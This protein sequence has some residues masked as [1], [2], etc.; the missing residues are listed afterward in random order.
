MHQ[1]LFFFKKLKSHP[2][3]A[4]FSDDQVN[5]CRLFVKD[6]ASKKCFLI[7]TGA[8]V[9]V[10][11]PSFHIPINSSNLGIK[12]FAANG[13]QI[14]TFGTK[15][16]HLDLGLRRN[17]S[18]NFIIADVSKPIIGSD[19]L[20]YYHLLP[21]LKRKAL[22]DG[23][24][25]LH[26]SGKLLESSSL[27]IKVLVH[28]DSVYNKLLLNYPDVYQATAI[29]GIKSKHNI[30]H[31]IETTG[32]PVFAKAR[33]LDPN[34]LQIAKKDF[35]FLLQ[36]GIIRPSKSNW[37]NPLHMV[38]KKNGEWRCVGDYRF[39]NKITVPDRYPIPF[40]TD[41]NVNIAGCSVF[42]KLDL[43]RTFYQIPVYPDDISKTAVIT[44]FGLYEF[45]KMPFGLRNA[46]QSFQRLMDEVLRGLP[47]VFVYIDDV[48]LFSKSTTEHLEHLKIIFDRFQEYGIVVNQGKCSFGKYE[49]DFL[50]FHISSDGILPTQ[51]KI[52]AI[53]NFPKPESIKDL[54]RFLAMINFYR[55]FLPHA[56][57]EQAPLN[58]LLK[59]SVKNDKRPVPWSSQTEEAF[60]KC[61]SSLSNSTLLFH[62]IS[63]A[64][65]VVKVDASDFAIGAVLEQKVG[66]DWQPL[67]F[68]TKK[69]TDTEKRYSTYDRELLAI[70]AAI[71]YFRDYV[72]GRE[73]S[74]HTDHKPLIFAFSQKPEKASPRQL[75]QLN[76]IGQFTTNFKH[77]KGTEN[78]V[79]DAFSRIESI[80]LLDYDELSKLQNKDTELQNLLNSNTSLNLQLVSIP[81][82]KT[83]I[84]CD[85]STDN[86]PR[87]YIPKD[88]RKSI[89]N[90]LHNLSHP[91][92]KTSTKLVTERYIWPFMKRDCRYWTKI[93]QACQKAK[94]SRHTKSPIGHFPLASRRFAEIHIDLVGP[95]LPSNGQR[96]LLTCVDR[97]SRWMEAFPMPN[98]S[99]DTICETFMNGWISRFGSPDVIH[100][101]R[102]RQFT[103]NN[104]RSLTQFLGTKIKFSTSYHPQSNGLV[105]RFHRTL[106]ASISCHE[107]S[108]WTKVLPLVL[109]GLRASV[110]DSIHCSP[111][112]IVY[113]EILQLPG[114]FFGK[115]TSL[116]NSTDFVAQ[117]Q[118]II[119]RI[120][121]TS[122]S[123]NT[124][125]SVF[126]NKDL[127]ECTHVWIRNDLIL[128]PL[129]QMFH[130]PYKVIAKFDKYF[131]LQIGNK[132][133]NVSIDRLKPVFLEIECNDVQGN[134]N[135]NVAD[136]TYKRELKTVSFSLGGE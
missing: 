113:G 131:T 122:S 3:I 91:G 121:P 39:L 67:S 95:L 10:I 83:K 69:L 116:I 45:L 75:R 50:G 56:A 119:S 84:F 52:E 103:S 136:I 104:F 99:S 21:D 25:L 38:P 115:T 27:G 65:L 32:P 36:F 54:R 82:T 106:K 90:G 64:E 26:V 70:Y 9:S 49:I 132:I 48:L 88:L 76:F 79:A 135:D 6:N 78:V 109:L 126:V 15:I 127:Q 124:K 16:L 86:F 68:F 98:C 130:G 13:S 58:N 97:F 43:V 112:E 94:I 18:W 63:D 107:E 1:T 108:Q 53:Q 72:E 62:P 77:V 101:D 44:P 17:F 114:Q 8:D 37:S 40:I 125:P 55:R 102:G 19:F 29:P 128:K 61:K 92:A 42:S 46:A 118:T 66:N 111:A 35:E 120:K 59:N 57:I 47:F 12:I 14:R 28:D 33:R 23:T 20:K 11:P 133:D 73:F 96:Y 100:T 4:T 51:S 5:S 41:A 81:G 31:H 30:Y 134:K 123:N 93:C 7:D 89:F 60:E 74:V 105:E 22:I 71:K 2:D 34:R 117:L 85:V 110:K 24:T 129:Q 87:P 80:S